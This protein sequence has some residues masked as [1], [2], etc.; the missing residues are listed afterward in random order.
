MFVVGHLLK[1]AMNVILFVTITLLTLTF[2]AWVCIV[3]ADI[4]A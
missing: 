3:A 4:I 2:S 1:I